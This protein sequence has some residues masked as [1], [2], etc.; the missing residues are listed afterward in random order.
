MQK[1]VVKT[2]KLRNPWAAAALMRRAGSHRAT[3]GALRQQAK[4]MLRREAEHPPLRRP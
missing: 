2:H 1:L 4:R 3:G